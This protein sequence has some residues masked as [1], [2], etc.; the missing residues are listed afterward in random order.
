MLL[1]IFSV[2]SVG[3]RFFTV[4]CSLAIHLFEQHLGCTAT[5]LAPAAL[6]VEAHGKIN[7]QEFHRLV[8][9]SSRLRFFNPSR[10]EGLYVVILQ[11]NLLNL[12]EVHDGFV[13]VADLQILI[14]HTCDL[15]SREKELPSLKSPVK[16]I[17]TTLAIFTIKSLEV[18]LQ[19]CPGERV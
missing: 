2:P 19:L 14:D 4:W 6:T 7:Y 5:A 15:P 11:L 17:L 1:T 13:S 12:I 8:A 16:I 10:V 18:S 9:S 3:P